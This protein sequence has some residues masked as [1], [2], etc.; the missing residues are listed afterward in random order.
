VKLYHWHQNF[1]KWLLSKPNWL[2]T[3]KTRMM[4]MSG[5]HCMLNKNSTI[6]IKFDEIIL[7]FH[8]TVIKYCS[9]LQDVEYSV[10]DPPDLGV[11]TQKARKSRMIF[12]F[13]RPNI[14][15]I[16]AL[17]YGPNHAALMPR[18]TNQNGSAVGKTVI[19]LD[20]HE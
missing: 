12:Q 15:W 2:C 11:L 8:Y 20:N 4:S 14:H 7:T 18:L 9:G 13:G 5:Q 6:P 19:I 1:T 3:P 17:S 10:V 16:W